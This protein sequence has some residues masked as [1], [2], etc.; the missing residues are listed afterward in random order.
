MQLEELRNLG[1][2]SADQLRFVGI[3]TPHDL[4]RVGAVAAYRMIRDQFDGVT[5]VLLYALEGALLDT[6][7]T[8]LPP[9]VKETLLA[10]LTDAGSSHAE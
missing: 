1:P 10:E 8:S 9:G 3:A 6:S 4:D 7:W 2:V 5:R